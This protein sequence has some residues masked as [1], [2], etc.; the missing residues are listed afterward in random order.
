MA[1]DVVKVGAGG[2]V[3]SEPAVRECATL[4]RGK[5]SE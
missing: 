5:Y 2:E 1:A 4:V 3:G